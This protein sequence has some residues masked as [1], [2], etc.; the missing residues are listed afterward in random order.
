MK[1]VMRHTCLT[2]LFWMMN[3]RVASHAVHFSTF[4]DKTHESTIKLNHSDLEA[5]LAGARQENIILYNKPTLREEEAVCVRFQEGKNADSIPDNQSNG[6]HES[7]YNMIDFI[8]PKATRR[9]KSAALKR[10]AFTDVPCESSTSSH[11]RSTSELNSS[12]LLELT[13]RRSPQNGYV[14]LEFRKNHL[15]NHSNASVFSK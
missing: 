13:L 6:P 14:K 12:K 8:E 5:S 3:L 2:H 15:L 4:S 1:E 9:L 7:S 11:G 10:V